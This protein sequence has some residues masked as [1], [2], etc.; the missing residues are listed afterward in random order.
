MVAENYLGD[1]DFTMFLGDNLLKNG[2]KY[3][4]DDFKK[5]KYDAMIVLT[6]VDEPQRYGIAEVENDRL[7]RTIEK[8][9]DTKSNLAITGVYI[10]TPP[11]FD[12]VK[13]LKPSWRNELEITDAIQG[14]IDQGYQVGHRMVEGWWKDTGKPEDLLEANQL[15]LSE[16]K[17][18]NRGT[19]EEGASIIGNVEIGKNSVVC[20]DTQIRG[21]AIIG[22]NCR[23]GP[24]S[25]VGPYTSIGN[26]VTIKGGE[27]EN[28]IIMDGATISCDKRIV[29]SLIGRDS[30]IVSNAA[31]PS[32]S[33]FVIG[34]STYIGI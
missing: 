34:D 25:Y 27:I 13:K 2:I 18:A 30:K 22:E 4:V 8:P 20:K 16:I 23:I 19:A 7:V 9:K 12:I 32:G 24:G 26:N 21:P 33:R 14:L 3:L 1:E 10:F 6:K 15:I 28:S 31:K 17:P 29:D 5:S 11:I